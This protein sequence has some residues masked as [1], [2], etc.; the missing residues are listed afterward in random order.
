MNIRVSLDKVYGK[1]VIRPICTQAH[2][3]CELAGTKT[4][5]AIYIGGADV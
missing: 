2:L 3:L 5:A 4:L 1:E